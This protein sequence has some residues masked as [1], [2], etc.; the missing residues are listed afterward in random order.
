[1][2]Q[3]VFQSSNP[4]VPQLAQENNGASTNIQ[5]IPKVENM[6]VAPGEHSMVHG[7]QAQPK[8]GIHRGR[9]TGLDTV[10]STPLML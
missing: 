8:A 4:K 1:M 3:S 9:V 6:A 10:A 7:I 5:P 2:F